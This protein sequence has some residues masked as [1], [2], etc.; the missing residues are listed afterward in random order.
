MFGTKGFLDRLPELLMAG[1]NRGA[2]LGH[3][4]IYS[5]TVAAAT[6]GFLLGVPSIAVSMA[7]HEAKHYATAARVAAGGV[8]RLVIPE[9]QIHAWVAEIGGDAIDPANFDLEEIDR[10]PFFC[11]DPA[12]DC[13]CFCHGKTS[14]T[15]LPDCRRLPHSRHSW[16]L[17]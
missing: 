8:A 17:I 4:T 16:K 13:C 10:N 9:V 15:N 11:P 7:G 12:G 2:N 1:I 6:E 3:D 5:G 14:G